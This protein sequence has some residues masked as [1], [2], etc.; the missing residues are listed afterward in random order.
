MLQPFP[1]NLQFVPI[2]F[3]R[4]HFILNLQ[5]RNMKRTMNEIIK[6]YCVTIL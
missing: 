4:L 2:V 1:N 3:S 6:K 5:S